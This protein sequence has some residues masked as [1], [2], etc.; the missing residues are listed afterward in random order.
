MVAEVAAGGKA[1]VVEEMAAADWAGIFRSKKPQ[2]Q[3]SLSDLH[4][5]PLCQR[6]CEPRAPSCALGC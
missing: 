3:L 4:S 6:R 1:V 5:L 2:V